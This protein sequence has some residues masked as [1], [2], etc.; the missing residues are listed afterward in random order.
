M[1]NGTRDI[2]VRQEFKNYCFVTFIVIERAWKQ[3]SNVFFCVPQ[4]KI[5]GFKPK[6]DVSVNLTSP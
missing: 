2:L 4:K 1:A 6:N 3:S 5:I